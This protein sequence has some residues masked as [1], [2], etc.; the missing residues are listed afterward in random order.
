MRDRSSDQIPHIPEQEGV[1]Q[2]E[3]G[4]LVERKFSIPF[5]HSLNET[6]TGVMESA[7][8]NRKH[9]K[10]MTVIPLGC[11]IFPPRQRK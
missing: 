4:K 11:D 5:I 8:S 7:K 3:E 10:R 9:Q 1:E 6:V 2:E